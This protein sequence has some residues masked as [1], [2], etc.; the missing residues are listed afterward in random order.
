MKIRHVLHWGAFLLLSVWLAIWAWEGLMSVDQTTSILPLNIP[1]FSPMAP[2]LVGTA[3]GCL[4]CFN[5]ATFDEKPRVRKSRATALAVARVVECNRTG[6]TVNDVPQYEIYMR[7]MPA[8]APEFIALL[9]VL[10]DARQQ[11]LLNEG[12]TEVVRFDPSHHDELLLANDHPQARRA[13]VSWRVD[14]GLLS[15][16]HARVIWEGVSAPASV[17]AIRPSGKRREGE[18][19]V[20][21]SLV[22]APKGHQ[23]WEAETT[24]YVRPESLPRIQVGSPVTAWCMPTN[25]NVVVVSMEEDFS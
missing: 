12:M 1:E 10:V 24:G 22:V 8:G 9:R 6:L 16:D 3:W 20:T 23:S 11:Y 7:V 15:A 14:R 25:P 13:M 18:Q 4:L 17:L 21:L 2:V 19:Q 5:P